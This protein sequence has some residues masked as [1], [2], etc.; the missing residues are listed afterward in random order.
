MV[1]CTCSSEIP[2]VSPCKDH[3]MFN[4]NVANNIQGATKKSDLR[5]ETVK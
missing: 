2:I 1:K 3:A 5:V 4:G